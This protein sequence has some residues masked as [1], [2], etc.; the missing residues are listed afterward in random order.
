[1]SISIQKA[2]ASHEENKIEYIDFFT[3][4]PKAKKEFEK[5]KKLIYSFIVRKN[6]Q[7]KSASARK[8]ARP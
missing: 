2:C 1:M 8:R 7:A 3:Y 4:K 6:K 5:N